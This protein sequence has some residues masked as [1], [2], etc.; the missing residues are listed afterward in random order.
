MSISAFKA[1]ELN[2]M[3]LMKLPV[4]FCYYVH[5]HKNYVDKKVTP[6]LFFCY[7]STINKKKLD[8]PSSGFLVLRCKA[9][10]LFSVSLCLQAIAHAK[11]IV[12]MHNTCYNQ[13][14]VINW[15]E[16]KS[17]SQKGC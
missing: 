17:S 7:I 1:K 11:K 10:D 8:I 3:I 9:K 4:K 5:L 12:N 16:K 14:R 2:A 15:M 6:K 13:T